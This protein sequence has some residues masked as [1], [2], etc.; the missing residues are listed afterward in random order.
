MRWSSILEELEPPSDAK[1]L[2]RAFEAICFAL[3]SD[4]DLE[5]LGLTVEQILDYVTEDGQE[6]VPSRL[7]LET[8]AGGSG[9]IE[10]F[11]KIIPNDPVWRNAVSTDFL[12]ANHFIPEEY[13]SSGILGLRISTLLDLLELGATPADIQLDYASRCS[14]LGD[15]KMSSVMRS[16]ITVGE[17]GG[18]FAWGFF[19]QSTTS[20]VPFLAGKV[21]EWLSEVDAPIREM[22]HLWLFAD[23]VADSD[24][25]RWERLV[26]RVTTISRNS[27]RD[28]QDQYHRAARSLLGGPLRIDRKDTT[29]LIPDVMGLPL[30]RAQRM[31]VE[32]GVEDILVADV[33]G[34][35][36]FFRALI[37]TDIVCGMLPVG[38]SP[39]GKDGTNVVVLASMHEGDRPKEP[40][41]AGAMRELLRSEYG[42][43]PFSSRA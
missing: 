15:A 42:D 38:G 43:V 11:S 36:G 30:D 25:L 28:G 40:L 7:Y 33:S 31:L 27:V 23:F 14:L 34:P 1:T 9:W 17:I 6:S 29:E 8:Q 35:K 19:T 32:V 22:G 4:E 41:I 24:R 37:A 18:S 13:L 10:S 12:I 39:V 16:A 20:P 21:E 2:H 26:G 5:F 3:C